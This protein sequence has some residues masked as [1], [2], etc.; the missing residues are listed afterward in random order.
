MNL[1]WSWKKRKPEWTQCSSYYLL[2]ESKTFLVALQGG[3]RSG[4]TFPVLQVIYEFCCFNANCGLI[5]SIVR[6]SGNILKRTVYKDFIKI[7]VS[8]GVY[9]EKMHNKTD[10]SFN[11]FG[12]T[13][14]FMSFDDP[15]SQKG[16]DS[17][18]L[19]LNEITTI[20]YENYFQ[21][22]IRTKMK[23]I[24]DYNPSFTNHYIEKEI[25]DKDAD[26]WIT[27]YKDNPFLPAEM[28]KNIEM[29]EQRNPRKWQ[30]YGLGLKSLPE[31]IV[32]PN[33]RVINNF[34]DVTRNEEDFDHYY[35]LDFGFHNP[36]ALVDI[37]QK[38]YK[39]YLKQRIYKTGLTNT[40]LIKEMERVKTSKRRSIYADTAEPDR[41]K[42]LL[43]A[44]FNAKKSKKDTRDNRI[45]FC[46]DYEFIIDHES[47][48]L[49]REFGNYVHELDKNDETKILEEVDKSEC[50]LIDGVEYGVYTHNKRV[51]VER[52]F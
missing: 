2:K 44:G 13:V 19:Y 4:K 1:E 9:S 31:N 46:K 28:V 45:Q 43:Q 34:T 30:I 50:H 26:F 49:I 7:L 52:I 47:P 3:T 38:E 32:Y 8:E 51:K 6:K 40:E 14:Q 5:I 33:H 36:S 35:G 10:K 15:E 37:Y 12:N 42:E 17:D 41:I 39:V 23:V 27:T 24:V 11:V 18:I 16:V 21:F 20:D 48:D 29:L 25:L 22:Y